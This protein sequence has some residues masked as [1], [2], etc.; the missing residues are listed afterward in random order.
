MA[1][2][3]IDLGFVNDDCDSRL[4]DSHYFPSKVGGKPAWLS[5]KPLPPTER[6]LCSKCGSNLAFLMQVYSPREKPEEDAFHRTLFLF[7]CRNSGCC[8]ANDGENFVVLRSQLPRINQFFSPDPPPDD[9]SEW[10][11]FQQSAS[12]Y[13]ALCAV[14]GCQ[15]TK[16]CGQCHSVSYCGKDHQTRHWKAGHKK[17]CGKSV[18]QGTVDIVVSGVTFP[19][20]DLEMEE[21]DYT[22]DKSVKDEEQALQEYEQC[23][24][25]MS[26]HQAADT[27]FSDQELEGMATQES[28]DDKQF[29]K[30]KKRVALYQDQV[31]RYCKGGEPLWVSIKHQ[32]KEAD[33]PDCSCGAPRQ[34]EFQVMP[35]LLNY[36]GVDDKDGNSLDWGTLCVYTCRDSC[37]IGNNY[38]TEFLWKQDFTAD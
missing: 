1:A 6:L 4:L 3:A 34:F 25:A 24:S 26:T 28:E 29:K 21:E 23:V 22:P 8:S 30:F 35:Q 11:D 5:L 13:Q 31:L 17:V 16:R 32:A 18:P 7:V 36:L 2:K 27:Q 38:V 15:G 9:P 12:K 10:N 33:I 20:F 37:A 19:E 14:C